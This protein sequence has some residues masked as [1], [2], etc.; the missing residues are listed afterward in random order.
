[1]SEKRS[2]SIPI[3]VSISASAPPP[4][5]PDE[6]H[7]PISFNINY[8]RP[9]YF[10]LEA[11]LEVTAFVRQ[12]DLL[13]FDPQM[14][15]ME[16]DEY[17]SHLLIKGWNCGNEFAFAS[18]LRKRKA[19]RELA[20]LPAAT[21]M[22]YWRWNRGRAERQAQ[23]GDTK[24]IPRIAF[25]RVGGEARGAAFWPDGGVPTVIPH[26]AYLIVDQE[27]IGSERQPGEENHALVAWEV[28]RS[29][30]ERYHFIE[31][32]NSFVLDDGAQPPSDLARS[33]RSLPAYTGEFA[34]LSAD[35]VL[36]RELVEKYA[37]KSIV[38]R[39]L[40][41]MRRRRSGQST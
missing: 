1:V 18:F 28:A 4:E 5:D 35:E 29:L 2:I 27:K 23:V 31:T 3:A 33:I 12:F 39:A 40:D 26:V 6:E 13:V 22:D 32:D 19:A 16:G 37:R 11:E 36:D 9:S 14:D 21:L 17:Q 34:P 7:L 25:V 41:F 8:F 20:T 30:L 24:S 10:I 15:G 38:K